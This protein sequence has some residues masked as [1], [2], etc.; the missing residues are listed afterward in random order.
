MPR[1]KSG[2]CVVGWIDDVFLDGPYVPVYRTDETASLA[3]GKGIRWYGFAD[4][5]ETVDGQ[6]EAWTGLRLCRSKDDAS[7]MNTNFYFLYSCK[8]CTVI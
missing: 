7:T 3:G 2:P 8:Y 5:V 6:T 4:V 1:V